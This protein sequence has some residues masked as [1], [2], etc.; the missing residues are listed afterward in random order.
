[1]NRIR[2]QLAGAMSVS[3]VDSEGEFTFELQL[4]DD[5]VGF[6][7]HF[8]GQPVLPGVCIVAAVL[9]AAE[10]VLGRRLRMKRLKSAKF[11]RTVTPGERVAGRVRV[12]EHGQGS[13]IRATLVVVAEKAAEVILQLP[14][15]NNQG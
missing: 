10:K 4:A 9:T 2:E 5:F 12:E 1:M 15:L 7:G 13:R 11:F 6:Q 3:P 14:S 8:P